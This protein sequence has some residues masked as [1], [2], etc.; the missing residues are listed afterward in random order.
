MLEC[1]STRH[2]KKDN[3]KHKKKVSLLYHN[4]ETMEN[5]SI[6]ITPKN[7]RKLLKYKP[8]Q[9]KA[10]EIGSGVKIHPDMPLRHKKALMKAHKNKRGVRLHFMPEELV[11]GTGFFDWLYNNIAKPFVNV[12][13]STYKPLAEVARPLVRQFAPEIAT[14]ASSFTGLPITKEQVLG[15]EELSKKVLGVGMKKGG[16]LKTNKT[17]AVKDLSGLQDNY[18]TLLSTQHPIFQT[19]QPSLP[20]QD[21]YGAMQQMGVPLRGYGVNFT[22]NSKDYLSFGPVLNK[23]NYTA[24]GSFVPS[25]YKASR[26]GRMVKLGTGFKVAGY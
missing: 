1:K 7:A 19:N 6:Q 15:A 22:E 9:L 18:S 3:V 14:A 2:K 5:L 24:G 25:G 12:V 11:Q 16:A 4:K 10:T 21:M 23:P 13:K 26:G 8:V 20:A 17:R